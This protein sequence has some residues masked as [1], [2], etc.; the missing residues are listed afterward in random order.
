[1]SEIPRWHREIAKIIFSFENEMTIIFMNI[2]VQV[3]IHP[4]DD[5]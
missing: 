2:Q 4:V 5:I 3:L 1:V